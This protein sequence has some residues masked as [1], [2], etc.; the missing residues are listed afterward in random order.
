MNA[1]ELVQ[2]RIA[3]ASLEELVT[4]RHFFGL[5][6]ASPVQRA[7]CR[8]ADGVP[9]GSLADD[10]AVR[11]AFDHNMSLPDARPH[12]VSWLAAV[13]VAKSLTAAAG[14]VRM[15]QVCEMPDWL[16]PGDIPRIPILSL[17]L[18]KAS[19]VMNHL[20]HSIAASPLLKMILLKE[21]SGD[22]VTLRHPTGR[23]I[24][25]KIVAGKKAGNAVVAFWLAGCIFDEFGKMHGQTDAVVNWDETRS[26]ALDRILPGGQI[27]NIGSPWA[28]EGPAHKQVVTHHGKPTVDL[29]VM[30]SP[31]WDAN[32]VWWTPAR[33]AR[34]KVRNPNYRTDVEAEFGTPEES[35]FSADLIRTSMRKEA[36]L[37]HEEGGDYAAFIDPATRGNAFTLVVVMR[38]GARMVVVLAREWV[39]SKDAPLDTAFVLREIIRACA[40]YGVTSASTDQYMGDALVSQAREL[41]DE[42]GEPMR[43]FA[44]HQWNLTESEKLDRALC[45]RTKLAAGEV[46]LCP[47]TSWRLGVVEETAHLALDV[48]R[49]KKKLT[50]ASAVVHLP[51]TTDGRHCDFW[52]PIGMA[53][54]VY[55][56]DVKVPDDGAVDEN[57][58]RILRF[59]ER[60]YAGA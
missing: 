30:R 3:D 6:T 1:A 34:A 56:D 55:L 40:P 20:V 8:V 27:W 41:R 16:K 38:R 45:F 2:K 13:R 43:P 59:R 9:L 18:D 29:V 44:L 36:L 53:M 5:T 4:S 12:E 39:G 23:K 19:A 47:V 50:Q 54:G 21:P 48:Q 57:E 10:A 7:F 28:P 46:E 35:F 25:V 24:V 22:E 37:L 52:P 31:G 60:E 33:V 51:V 15:S 58:E 42:A 26:V 14:C 49:V 11:R 32:P 17:D